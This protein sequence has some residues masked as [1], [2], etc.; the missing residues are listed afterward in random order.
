MEEALIVTSSE[1]QHQLLKP[2]F[3]GCDM[4]RSCAVNI[5]ISPL[6]L[7]LL[8]TQLAGATAAP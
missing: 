2:Q 5:D 6:R 7:S 8:F 3:T 4:V 1:Q